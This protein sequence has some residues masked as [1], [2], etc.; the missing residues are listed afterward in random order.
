MLS[1]LVTGY[2]GRFDFPRRT[3]PPTLT[4]LLATLPRT[5]STWFSHLLWQTGCLGAPLEYLNFEQAGPYYFAAKSTAAQQQLWSS[6]LSRRTSPNGVFGLKC[7]PDQLESLQQG[8]PQLL[9]DI[10]STFVTDV[11]TPRVIYLERDDRTAHAIS[12]AR[13]T[14]SGVW[15]REQEGER[16][17][18]VTYSE[19]AIERARESLD[20]Q[21]GAWEEFFRDLRIEPYRISYEAILADPEKSLLEVGKSLGV[22]LDSEARI[23]VPAVGKQSD[24]DSKAWA[25][26]FARADR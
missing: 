1:R 11:S 25:Q 12:Y 16:G 22:E 6:L 24:Q 8:N 10:M 9:T 5:G 3:S 26:Q 13:A 21:A 20:R 18:E 7:F 17:T 19:I 23:E 4:Y 14:L 2:E 15:R